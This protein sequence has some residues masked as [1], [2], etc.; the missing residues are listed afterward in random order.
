MFVSKD[1]NHSGIADPLLASNDLV[2]YLALFTGSGNE[3]I[4]Y[5]H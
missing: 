1:V 5:L 2:D 4:D 3:A